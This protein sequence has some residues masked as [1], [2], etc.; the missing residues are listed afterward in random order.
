MPPLATGLPGG[1]EG[2]ASGLGEYIMDGGA[3]ATAVAI[4]PACLWCETEFD[5]RRGGGA[6]QRFCQPKCR[7]AF[8]SAGRRWAEMAVLSGVI[9]IGDLR[10]GSGAPCMRAGRE[11]GASDYPDIGYEETT[12][13]EAQ[14]AS[15]R[16]L[17]LELS[18]AP[19]GILD[20]CRLGWLDV[21][22][23][24]DPEIVGEAVAQ[25]ANAALSLRLRPSM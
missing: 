19:D 3:T 5:P 20:L 12:L 9:T 13:S 22:K 14:R 7:D 2:Q 18:I 11:E 23:R 16:K 6:P 15:A 8:H 24:Q 21:D 10:N 4:R 17:Q 25:L 1:A